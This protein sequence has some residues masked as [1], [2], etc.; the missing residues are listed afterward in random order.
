MKEPLDILKILTN[1]KN[2]MKVM[3]FCEQEYSSSGDFSGKGYS[4]LSKNIQQYSRK[5]D[6][7]SYVKK[8]TKTCKGLKQGRWRC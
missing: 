4:K 7:C 1:E 3:R 5:Q 2:H 6:G 8:G